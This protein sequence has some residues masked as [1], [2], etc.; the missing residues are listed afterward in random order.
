MLSMIGFEDWN[1]VFVGGKC[2]GS[3]NFN[4]LALSVFFFCLRDKV[5]HKQKVRFPLYLLG[6]VVTWLS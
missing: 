4:L 6:Q 3:Q 1:C 2:I 5:Y